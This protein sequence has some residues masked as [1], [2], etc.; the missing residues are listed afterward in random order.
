[1]I[2]KLKHIVSLSLVLILIVPMTTQLFDAFFHHH[3]HITI[4]ENT[5]NHFQVHHDKCPIPNFQLSIFSLQKD[6][7]ETNKTNYSDPFI[8]LYRSDYYSDK[9]NYSFLLRAPPT[10]T[11]SI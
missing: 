4:A 2:K 11:R 6:K 1:M 10:Q 7:T 5:E 9:S 3:Y 8:I